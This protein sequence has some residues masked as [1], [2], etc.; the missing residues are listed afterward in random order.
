MP[1]RW[2]PGAEDLPRDQL[3]ALQLEKM[4]HQ[5]IRVYEQS[6]YYRDKFDAVGVNPYNFTTLEQ[7]GEYP[8]FD[9]DEER[10]SQETSKVTLGHPLGSGIVCASVI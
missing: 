3:R 8:F 6:P 10:A 5:L 2:K 1:N 7:L 9:K 4:K